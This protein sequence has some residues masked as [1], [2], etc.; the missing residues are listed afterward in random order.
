M[1]YLATIASRPD[2]NLLPPGRRFLA[3]VDESVVIYNLR[4]D[5]NL[6]ADNRPTA[7]IASWVRQFVANAGRPGRHI[8]QDLQECTAGALGLARTS[9]FTPLTMLQYLAGERALR[10]EMTPSLC[11]AARQSRNL[12]PLSIETVLTAA[13][14]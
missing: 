6:D 13:E 12:N 10:S 7:W 5:R 14:R 9:V 8:P 3:R 11:V 1:A 4:V 2:R